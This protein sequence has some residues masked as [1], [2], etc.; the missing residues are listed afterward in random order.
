MKYTSPPA[1]KARQGLTPRAPQFTGTSTRKTRG[2]ETFTISFGQTHFKTIFNGPEEARG[3]AHGPGSIL[4]KADLREGKPG[5]ATLATLPVVGCLG[6]CGYAY[7]TQSQVQGCVGHA[8][9]HTRDRVCRACA[10]RNA[11]ARI[12]KRQ[13]KLNVA[14]GSTSLV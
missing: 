10:A 1:G 13:R 3:S 4:A 14:R 11:P 6:A 2:P 9:T 7:L 5:P 8:S 12:V